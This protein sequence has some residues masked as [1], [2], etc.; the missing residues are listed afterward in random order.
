M[1][2]G[3]SEAVPVSRVK[4]LELLDTKQ[5]LEASSQAVVLPDSLQ[6]P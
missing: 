5:V 3:C 1:P 4:E 2:E 6:C